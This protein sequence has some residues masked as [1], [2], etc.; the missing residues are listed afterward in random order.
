MPLNDI[1]TVGDPIMENLFNYPK[2]SGFQGFVP[3]NQVHFRPVFRRDQLGTGHVRLMLLILST[4]DFVILAALRTKEI[5]CPARVIVWPR[6]QE[7]I[8]F[9]P[10]I[11]TESDVGDF[12]VPKVPREL[13]SALE[14]LDY[15]WV[16]TV[17][18]MYQAE[19]VNHWDISTGGT[20]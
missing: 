15:W 17:S 9:C 18:T 12:C 7:L 1:L 4:T 11:G 14:A 3:V 8:P 19:F 5:P 16:I 10:A 2:V 13:G 6:L 20:D